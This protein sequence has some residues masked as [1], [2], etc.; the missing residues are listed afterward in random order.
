MRITVFPDSS[1]NAWLA[2]FEGDAEVLDLFGTD[3]LPTAYTLRCG[4]AEV[5]AALQ[6]F[7][8]SALVRLVERDGSRPH[9][10]DW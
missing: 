9:P 3:T 1:R 5:R 4:G 8:P 10:E 2:R 6:K 7:N